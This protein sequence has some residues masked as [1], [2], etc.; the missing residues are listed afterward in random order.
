M[1]VDRSPDRPYVA[2][3]LVGVLILGIVQ[4]SFLPLLIQNAPG[5][6]RAVLEFSTSH[7]SKFAAPFKALHGDG[8]APFLVLSKITVTQVESA[9]VRM[10]EAPVS[11][12]DRFSLTHR[13]LRAPPSA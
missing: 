5:T 4:W 2:F 11:G 8:P 9:I 6:T 1:S 13:P 12:P 10:P 3:L 7:T